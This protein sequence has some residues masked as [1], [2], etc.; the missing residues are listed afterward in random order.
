MAATEISPIR[1]TFEWEHQ[2]ITPGLTG[3]EA[4]NG[5]LAICIQDT[6]IWHGTKPNSGFDWAWIELLEFLALNWKYIITD[7]WHNFFPEPPSTLLPFFTSGVI[8]SRYIEDE[9][10]ID[11][12]AAYKNA[13]DLAEAVQGTFLPSIWIVSDADGNGWV[14]GNGVVANHPFNELL[15]NLAY[16]G[17]LIAGRLEQS[18]DRRSVIVAEEWDE[19]NVRREP[20]ALI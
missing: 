18:T 11:K 12:Y 4:T 1:F 5:T 10:A 15:K 20:I 6:P 8:P 16:M 19:W 3:V 2:T 9:K 14:G 7:S 13:H 17:D